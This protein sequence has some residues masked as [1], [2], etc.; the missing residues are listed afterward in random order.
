MYK[1]K[2]VKHL[3]FEPTADQKNF[4]QSVEQF[5]DATSENVFI[6]N[7]YAGTGKTSIISAL[8]KS[9]EEVE[10]GYVLLAPTGRAAKVLTN[11]SGRKAFTIHKAIY[12]LSM[13]KSG[14][15][16]F[17]LQNNKGVDVV[18]IVD[19]ASMIS[20]YS[21][22]ST[23]DSFGSS[24]FQDLLRFVFSGKRCKLILVGDDAQLPP[25]KLDYSPA[26]DVENVKTMVETEVGLA[27]LKEVVRQSLDSG[28][29]YNAT[30]IRKNLLIG[31]PLQLETVGYDDVVWLP[32][33]ELEDKLNY[34][35]SNYGTETTLIITRSN[36]RA[37]IYNREIRNRILMREGE[38]AASDMLM[39]VKNN[40][41]WLDEKSEAGFI[42][43][44]DIIE[45]LKVKR[46]ED[47]YG[48][49]FAEATVRLTDYPD[50]PSMDVKLL[51]DTIYLETPSLSF[52]D[53]KRLFNTVLEDYADE[54]TWK[55]KMEKMR[56]NPYLNCLQ[57]KFSYAVTCHKAQ[58]GQWEH[59]FI[60][61]GY[62]TDDMIGTDFYRWL[63]TAITR[64]TQ[65]VYLINFD[66]R[67]KAEE[68]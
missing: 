3:G 54:P 2:I 17:V 29:L 5:L 18:F 63:Y 60:D 44:G 9:L 45:V 37:N 39:V 4:I 13:D 47:I 21:G 36:K 67:F 57:V 28:I 23:F 35:Y 40:Y 52:E 27:V 62:L 20:D 42:A 8:V 30:L 46:Y 61:H 38:L 24:V 48:F 25:V 64:A 66:K 16:K 32:G 14:S 50:E 10:K 33:S 41:F 49:H 51:L 59:V 55:K 65:A 6:V 7:G 56:Q 11:Y 34:V 53:N 1:E 22:D 15:A 12:K 58:G 68:V 31:E 19:E 43:N 26:L